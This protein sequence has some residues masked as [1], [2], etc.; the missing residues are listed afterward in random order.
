MK[1]TFQRII[2]KTT[3]SDGR[4]MKKSPHRNHLFPNFW[5]SISNTWL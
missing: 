4:I 5:I 3:A 2:S 1:K